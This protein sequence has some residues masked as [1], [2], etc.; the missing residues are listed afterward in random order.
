MASNWTDLLMLKGNRP[1]AP[2]NRS[3]LFFS[4]AQDVFPGGVNSLERAFTMVGGTPRFMDQGDG[5]YL[6]DVDGNR[7]IDYLL[8]FGPLILGHA[9]HRVLG[10]AI[11][12]MR[13]VRPGRRLTSN[14][15]GR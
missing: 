6:M 13:C 9:S 4:D 5:A 14:T 8:A 1:S 7:Y 10:P 11:E 2:G 15:S 12:A 3:E